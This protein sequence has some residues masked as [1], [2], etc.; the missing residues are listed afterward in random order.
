MLGGI[1]GIANSDRGL[2]EH[3]LTAAE[4]GNIIKDFCETFGIEDDQSK[5]AENHYQLSS[6]K[7]TRI[8]GKV[9][10][11]LSVFSTYN[12][13]FGPSDVVFNIFIIKVLPEKEATRFLQVENI[14]QERYTSLVK[15]K[16]ERSGSI[17]DTLKKERLPTF[18]NNN[19]T[20]KVKIDNKNVHV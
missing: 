1:K 6:S 17:W 11:L 5:K 9:E 7:N 19:K 14:G 18:I 4:L 15:E 10:K 2:E 20:V 16:L 3:F 8:G 12:I 13:N